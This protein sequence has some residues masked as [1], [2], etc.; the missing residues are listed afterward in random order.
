MEWLVWIGA[1]L[2][3]AGVGGLL[4]CVL[5]ALRLRR[6][7]LAEDEKRI[8]LQRVVLVNMVALLVSAFGL[9]MVVAGILLG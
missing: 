5:R 8:G 7:D 3:L 9:M 6:P 4:W 1:A 2:S